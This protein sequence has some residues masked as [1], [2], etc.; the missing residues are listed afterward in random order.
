MTQTRW[1]ELDGYFNELLVRPDSSLDAALEASA[2][3]GLPPYDVTPSQGKLL[4][5]V[6]RAQGARAILEIGTL[7]GYSTIWL[8]RAL[9]ADGHLITLEVDRRYAEAARANVARA[10]LADRV[11]LRVG[12]ALETLPELVAEGRGP[13]DL[14]FIDADKENYPEY[15]VWALELS[16]RGTLIVA[17]NIVRGGAVLDQASDDPNVRGAR[18]FTELLAAEPRV[19][20]TAIQTVGS[21]GHDGFALALVTAD[22]P[23]RP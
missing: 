20:A 16:R 19:S 21:K 13:F 12:P 5:L 23:K 15:L 6:A 7:G 8:G 10:G 18:R 9:P 1:A 22:V 14:I 3:A 2:A 4:G 11:E 17:D